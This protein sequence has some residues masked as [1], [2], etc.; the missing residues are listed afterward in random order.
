[1]VVLESGHVVGIALY[2]G[3]TSAPAGSGNPS[4][5]T[6]TRSGA[7]ALGIT[8]G[9]SLVVL[10]FTEKLGSPGVAAALLDR[11]SSLDVIDVVGVS[12]ATFIRLVGAAEVLLG[13]LLVSGAASELVALAAAVPFLATVPVFGVIELVGHLPIYG[14]LLALAAD[15]VAHV[16]PPSVAERRLELR[17]PASLWFRLPSREAFPQLRPGR[18]PGRGDHRARRPGLALST[19]SEAGSRERRSPLKY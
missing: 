19:K 4:R 11:Y 16:A 8:L 7:R 3:L 9:V 12:E 13:L 14:A 17:R 2:L 1:M 6:G 18:R 5:V 10:A 15:G